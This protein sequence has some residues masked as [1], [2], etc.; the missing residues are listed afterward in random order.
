[1][2]ARTIWLIEG[3][4]WTVL[5]VVWGV[6]LVAHLINDT[7]WHQ[8]SIAGLLCCILAKM[9]FRNAGDAIR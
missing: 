2:R 9:A 4:V 8:A 1:M 3:Y 6:S 7:D 5:C